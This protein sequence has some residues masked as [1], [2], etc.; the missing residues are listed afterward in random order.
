MHGAVGMTEECEAQLFYR[1]AVVE[2]VRWG[3]PS[4][5]RLLAVPELAAAV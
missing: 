2:S 5:L 1:H 4:R 3:S